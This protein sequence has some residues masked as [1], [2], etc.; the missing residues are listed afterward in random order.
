MYSTQLA[1][2]RCANVV[3]TFAERGDNIGI[4]TGCSNV[5]LWIRRNAVTK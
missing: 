3:R 4:I 1:Q 5:I 2:L